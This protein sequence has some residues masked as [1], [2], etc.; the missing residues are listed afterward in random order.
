MEKSIVEEEEEVDV[1]QAMEELRDWVRKEQFGHLLIR[2][3]AAMG[4]LAILGICGFSL[5]RYAPG[6]FEK[7]LTLF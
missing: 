2:S 6:W 7:L 4:V 3:A 5:V 1:E